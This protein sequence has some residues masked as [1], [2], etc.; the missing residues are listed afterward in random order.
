MLFSELSKSDLSSMLLTIDNLCL[1][2]KAVLYNQGDA[3]ESVFTIR[4]GLVRLVQHGANGA[5]R[6][7]RL[8][9]PGSVSGLEAL[10]NSH[11]RH[12]AEA[13]TET[14]VC[15]IPKQV[16]LQI[17]SRNASLHG[18]LMERWQQS[19]DDA[20]MVIT[21]LSTGTVQARVARFLLQSAS[22]VKNRDYRLLPREDLAALLGV[23]L[24]T[25]SRVFAEFKRNGWVDEKA[26]DFGID[27]EQL[28][29][30]AAD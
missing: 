27:V 3:G 4:K 2:A 24:E 16:L 10:V 6:I 25:V 14:D 29:R 7:V 28:E 17:E 18:A 9:K 22:D 15:R 8:L 5:R 11:Y 1:P 12:T 13:V 19:L 20:D 30:V 23:T 26:P 21:Q